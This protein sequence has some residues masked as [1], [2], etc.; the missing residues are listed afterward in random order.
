MVQTRSN[1]KL[2]TGGISRD[3]I[4]KRFGLTGQEK[5]FVLEADADLVRRKYTSSSFR[6]DGT[7]LSKKIRV[8]G[9]GAYGEVALWESDR[10]KQFA[11]KTATGS[12]DEISAL[13]TEL[14]ALTHL[15]ETLPPYLKR[16]FVT[17]KPVT[18][19]D[20]RDSN[21]CKRGCVLEHLGM[22]VIPG[23]VELGDFL[24]HWNTHRWG[25]SS[26]S[27]GSMAPSKTRLTGARK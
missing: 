13:R 7:T 17:P 26:A 22:E 8:L 16:F 6:G 12:G 11:V 14:K 1:T 2:L 3:E 27:S 25:R 21:K 19:F 4:I 9:A 18:F 24:E 10:G 5:T 15:H 20:M 23:S